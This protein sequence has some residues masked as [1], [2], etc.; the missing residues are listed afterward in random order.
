MKLNS[1]APSSVRLLPQ[2]SKVTTK[3]FSLSILWWTQ[4][5][6]FFVGR[7]LELQ[8]L[9]GEEVLD[10]LNAEFSFY[11]FWVAAIFFV[12]CFWT[13]LDYGQVP[14]LVIVWGLWILT[15]ATNMCLVLVHKRTASSCLPLPLTGHV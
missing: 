7:L 8:T 9:R 4:L 1:D 15:V 5:W 13:S 10:D 3:S 2:G 14:G 6:I 11:G 12:L